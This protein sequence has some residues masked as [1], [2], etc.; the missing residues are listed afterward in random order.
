MDE[1]TLELEN[2]KMLKILEEST[3]E[4]EIFKVFTK[5]W[6]NFVKKAL[7]KEGERKYS[8]NYENYTAEEIKKLRESDALYNYFKYELRQRWDLPEIFSAFFGRLY[9]HEES[10]NLDRII[11]AMEELFL[12]D[13][14]YY[15][16][17]NKVLAK[18]YDELIVYYIKT[19]KFRGMEVSDKVWESIRKF[20]N[21]LPKDTHF[22]DTD[23]YKQCWL[24]MKNSNKQIYNVYPIKSKEEYEARLSEFTFDRRGIVE[25]N[26]EYDHVL[27]E[28][29]LFY[30]DKVSYEEKERYLR[31]M[32][33]NAHDG[34]F[35]ETQ[36]SRYFKDTLEG[37]KILDNNP[38]IVFNDILRN[39]R[40]SYYT[41]SCL[42]SDIYRKLYIQMKMYYKDYISN[43]AQYGEE[44]VE[45]AK[46]IMLANG[47]HI[48]TRRYNVRDG[49]ENKND[50]I[51]M[52]NF[53]RGVRLYDLLAMNFDMD[54]L[55]DDT[56]YEN[57]LTNFDYADMAF[58]LIARDKSVGIRELDE[59][60]TK[61]LYKQ[62][63]REIRD[64]RAMKQVV[65]N[66][67]FSN[68]IS[69]RD[70]SRKEE[71]DKCF[72]Y[73][74]YVSRKPGFDLFS[75]RECSD[76]IQIAKSTDNEFAKEM[77]EEIK[78]AMNENPEYNVSLEE[79]KE[80]AYNFMNNVGDRPISKDLEDEFNTFLKM[81]SIIKIS[82]ERG[83]IPQEFNKFLIRQSLTENSILNSN[84]ERYE[85]V[86]ER[87]VE[88]YHLNKSRE[89][90][91]REN[92]KSIYFIRNRSNYKPYIYIGPEVE[93]IESRTLIHELLHN[94]TYKDI[95]KKERVAPY[96]N[97][98]LDL[99][100]IETDILA[101]LE[102]LRVE[103]AELVGKRVEDVES[104]EER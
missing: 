96:V 67:I 86:L 37:K 54:K 98:Y 36:T 103:K 99:D 85:S 1:K 62:Y 12:E 28:Y 75:N 16:V 60:D 29:L 93:V 65:D 14:K 9:P 45:F 61:V 43:L 72:E 21:N 57:G 13:N 18:I 2:E 71:K 68:G 104:R 100:S 91:N 53:L 27:G 59:N 23:F 94:P 77:E 88:N 20:Y 24:P 49:F 78:A 19:T 101:K 97:Q 92:K 11:G 40:E 51:D 8:I 69:S 22:F 89:E 46:N 64:S 102:A 79:A 32:S 17:N 15:K 95:M 84:E 4:L 87:A 48:F 55:N 33:K 50:I 66:Y 63:G 52:E 83:V 74:K 35:Y 90:L 58:E 81:I 38:F 3:D 25:D 5:F 47:A 42:N 41:I 7:V 70:Y 82:D 76:F 39:Y 10:K 26:L 31:I 73:I 30:G 34:K 56:V 44:A 80:R 6:D